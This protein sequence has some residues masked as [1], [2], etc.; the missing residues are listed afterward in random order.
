MHLVFGSVYITVTVFWLVFALWNHHGIPKEM[1]FRCV[2]LGNV[3]YFNLACF[4]PDGNI[5][6]CVLVF[7]GEK[8]AHVHSL[9]PEQTKVW[10]HCLR[11]HWHIF[12]G[13]MREDV[14][15]N[16]KRYQICWFK[17]RAAHVA[18][19]VVVLNCNFLPFLF[20]FLKYDPGF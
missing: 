1:V 9:L 17:K 7:L 15:T 16:H 6:F 20:W 4:L 14:Y 8:V 18:V 12:W 11:I 2:I 10:A 19:A 3:L 5:S 13:K